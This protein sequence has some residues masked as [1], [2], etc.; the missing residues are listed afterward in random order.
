MF[1][2]TIK[3][4]LQI[5]L[6]LLTNNIVNQKYYTYI[7][8]TDFFFQNQSNSLGLTNTHYQTNKILKKLKE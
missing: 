3:V 7:I 1:N 8:V 5:R 2:K 6:Q 4:D